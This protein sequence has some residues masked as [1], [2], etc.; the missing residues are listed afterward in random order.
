MQVFPS[1]RNQLID[2]HSKLIEWFLYGGNTGIY[3]VKAYRW[4]SF[5]GNICS[6]KINDMWKCYDPVCTNYRKISMYQYLNGLFGISSLKHKLLED[7]Y[8]CLYL[9]VSH[10]FRSSRTICNSSQTSSSARNLSGILQN[11]LRASRHYHY[12]AFNLGKTYC[13]DVKRSQDALT[14]NATFTRYSN[15]TSAFVI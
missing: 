9:A 2:F 5:K 6:F 14:Y 7:L 8:G 3:W 4:W 1:Y 11:L 13:M 10:S 15:G 12:F